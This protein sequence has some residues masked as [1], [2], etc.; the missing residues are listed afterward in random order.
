MT[1]ALKANAP[2]FEEVA[3]G[4]KNFET[5][6][7][8]RKFAVGD[9]ILLQ[10]HDD[11]NGYSGREHELIITNVFTDQPKLGLKQNFCI[12][13]FTHASPLVDLTS[14]KEAHKIEFEG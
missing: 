9:K 8:D 12:I 3:S 2:F 4:K 14:H 7:H 11:E 5:R 6:K 1:H 13:S 10:E